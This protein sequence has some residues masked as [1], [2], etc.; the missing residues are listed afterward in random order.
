MKNI[1]L[2]LRKPLA[3]LYEARNELQDAFKEF[4]FTLDGKLIGDIGEAIAIEV[5]DLKKLK[6]G[7]K[8]HDCETSEGKLVQIKT[9]QKKRRCGRIA[10]GNSRPEFNNLIAIQ[11]DEN[12]M[13]EVIYNGLGKPITDRFKSIPIKQAYS[14]SVIHLKELDA[15]IKPNERITKRLK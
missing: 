7:T 2:K 8:S 13:Y 11:I 14:I 1:P 6:D 9:T 15:E 5:F 4:K 3:K 12:G 10:L